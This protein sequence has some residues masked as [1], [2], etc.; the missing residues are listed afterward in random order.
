MLFGSCEHCNKPSSSAKGEE[1]L[2]PWNYCELVEDSAVCSSLV[3]KLKLDV[4]TSVICVRSVQEVEFILSQIV[5][6]G[7]LEEEMRCCGNSYINY[8]LA[9]PVSFK[10]IACRK[11][12]SGS[13]SHANMLD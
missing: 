3:R 12:Y 9:Q 1:F 5:F 4:M 2:A 6:P 8:R 7:D 10:L 11:P 13:L